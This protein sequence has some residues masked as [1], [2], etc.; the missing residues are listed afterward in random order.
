MAA[1]LSRLDSQN[2]D[3]T[4]PSD[5]KLYH[6]QFSLQEASPETFGYTLVYSHLRIGLQS[7]L[8]PSGFPT[9]ILYAFLISPM[10]TTWPA[11][12][13]LDL[14]TLITFSKFKMLLML[15][16]LQVHHCKWHKSTTD[17]VICT[18][19]SSTLSTFPILHASM[20]LGNVM[21][22]SCLVYTAFPFTVCWYTKV[23][24]TWHLIGPQH[25]SQSTMQS[26]T[27]L[28]QINTSIASRLP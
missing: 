1:K 19:F 17:L 24:M 4:V 7:G 12:I 16:H 27:S 14:I 26:Y 28:H 20:E 18:C 10:R 11:H 2:S 21:P 3:T 8:L 15:W 22:V 5:R 25:K 13:I 6:L 23:D 9:K